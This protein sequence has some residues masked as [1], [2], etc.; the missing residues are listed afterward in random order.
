MA[1][2]KKT[3]IERFDSAVKEILEKYNKDVISE[4]KEITKEIGKEGVKLLKQESKA[5]VGRHSRRRTYATQWTDTIVRETQ[6]GVEVTI[7]SRKYQL[8]HLLEYSHTTG[9]NRGGHF[10][11][12]PHIAP[13]EKEIINKYK[14]MIED[15][16]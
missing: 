1:T 4:V 13:V 5:A 11:A 2:V 14:K 7:Y 15:K 9:R 16:L 8:P 6:T 12:I 3:P 10:S